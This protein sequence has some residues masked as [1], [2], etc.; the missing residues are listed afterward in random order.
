MKITTYRYAGED[1]Y[2][3]ISKFID[4][5]W[6]KNHIYV[7]DRCLFDWTFGRRNLWAENGHSVA[8]AEDGGELAGVLGGIPFAFN[9]F[10][11]TSNGVWI[12]NYVI[13]PEYRRGATALKL[14]SMF[15][16]PEYEAVVAFGINPATAT[17]Y[18]V[19]R[20]EVLPLIPRHF[21]ILPEAAQRLASLLRL[22]YEDWGQERAQS[23]ADQFRLPASGP[24]PADYQETIPPD[25]DEPDW[26]E[27]ARTTV[28]AARDYDYLSW[29]YLQHPRFQYRVLAVPEGMRRGLLIWR[30]ETIQRRTENGREDV[31]RIGR[32]V[33]FMPSSA[34]NARELLA[35]LVEKLR[36]AGAFGADY[37]DYN[38]DRRRYM[39]EAGFQETGLHA[40]GSLI[41]SR[42]QPL[43]GKDGSIM[44]ASFL[45][46]D[47]PTCDPAGACPW[48]WTKSDSDQDR[49]N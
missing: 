12:V 34:K 44:S 26:N 41:P 18:K 29:R 24:V 35:L 21:G 32:I 15:R 7:R 38:S 11:K 1:E 22:V 37:Y 10:G 19:L 6:A 3:R 49:P 8:I 17:I 20:G 43:D 33:E 14:L 4:E 27:I 13:R 9:R 36:E 42:F 45:P 30:L 23:V 2:P 5:H 28:G 39:E 25:W 40:D 48:Y 31:E 47:A 16:R 46:K